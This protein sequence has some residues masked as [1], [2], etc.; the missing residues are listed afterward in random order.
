M[1]ICCISDIHGNLIPYPSDFWKGLDECE[2]LLICGD[3]L[4]LSIQFN[5]QS[6]LEWLTNH[7]KPW[8]T[9]LP[10]KQV[11]FI[12][13][14]HDAV[15]ERDPIVAKMMFPKSDK[16]TYICH[17]EV[18]HI[19][20]QDGKVYK[21]FGTPYCHIFGNWPFMRSE[22]ALE[23]Y[24]E[25]IPENLDVLFTHDA[26]YGVS[27]VC[28]EGWAADGK[29]KGCP[30]LAEAVLNKRPARLLHGHL[31]STAHEFEQLGETLVANCSIL[32][33][34]YEIRY[35][36]LIIDLSNETSNNQDQ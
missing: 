8:A 7:F 5:Y 23:K 10:V 11:Y 6:S 35:Y 24:F 18:E 28:L 29:H 26:P 36:P 31:H 4:P 19:S 1:K 14:N 2:V 25:I 27:D 15:F 32:D 21:M 12:A 3:I 17:E 13:G 16:I 30:A 20:E 22:G 9:E 33:E 34:S